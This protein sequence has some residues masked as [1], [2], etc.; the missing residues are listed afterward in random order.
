MADT[1]HSVAQ[2]LHVRVDVVPG[3]IE[4]VRYNLTDLYLANDGTGDRR[5]GHY[6]VYLRDPR[7]QDKSKGRD[8]RP[9]WIGRIENFDRTRG[10]DVLAAEGLRL[11]ARVNLD[12]DTAAADADLVAGRTADLAQIVNG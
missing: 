2:M 3:G 11:A 12:A 4:Q 1:A 9:G 5:T 10:R 6:D 8:K 7:G